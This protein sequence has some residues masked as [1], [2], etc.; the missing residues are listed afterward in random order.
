MDS[1]FIAIAAFLPVLILLVIVHELGHFVTAKM[2]G[3]VVQEFG[4]G[5]P[6]KLF[7]RRWKG[8]DYSINL[9]PLGGFVKLLGE[10]DPAEKG[11]LAG[12]GIPTR[13]LVLSAGSAMNA[14]LPIVLFSAVYMIPKQAPAGPVEIMQ[15]LP[16]SPAEKAGFRPGDRIVQMNDRAIQNIGDVGLNIQLNLGSEMTI[17]LQRRGDDPTLSRTPERVVTRVTPRWNPPAGQGAT[18]IVIGMIEDETRFVERSYPI[19]KAIPLGVRH[20]TDMLTIFK[21]GITGLFASEK[22]DTFQ[23]TGPIGIARM[24]GEVAQQGIPT[25]LEWTAL[26]SVNL[27][28]LNMLPIPMLDGGRVFFILLEAVRGGKRIPPE[29]EGIV[30]LAGFILLMLMIIIVSYYDILKI[31]QGESLFP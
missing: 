18:G 6:P 7:S 30:H 26:L 8:T 11:S 5:Y 9:L 21:N 25:L 19:W 13:L 27:A 1:F 23:V 29:R 20:T 4:F 12:K 15:V 3:I 28:I 14:L 22:K 24:T 17:A 16:D 31:I 10:E 2:S